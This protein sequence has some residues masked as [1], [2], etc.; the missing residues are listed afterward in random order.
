MVEAEKLE[1]NSMYF[2]IDFQVSLMQRLNY[3]PGS[4][5]HQWPCPCRASDT[6]GHSQLWRGPAGDRPWSWCPG[7]SILGRQ[8]TIKYVTL[9]VTVPNLVHCHR[10]WQKTIWRTQRLSLLSATFLGLKKKKT[11][12]LSW[13]RCE[14]PR[15]TNV[16]PTLSQICPF[17]RT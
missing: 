3:P 17:L 4:T 5:P 12:F 14:M 2:Q 16:A 6:G 10:P 1:E 7:K 13:S 8:K 9:I 15:A 11:T